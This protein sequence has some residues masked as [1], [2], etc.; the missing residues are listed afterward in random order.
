MIQK[1]LASLCCKENMQQGTILGLREPQLRAEKQVPGGGEC[2]VV[3][4]VSACTTKHYQPLLLL[5]GTLHHQAP[6]SQLLILAHAILKLC[7]S[8]KFHL[9]Q[10]EANSFCIKNSRCLKT[11]YGLF[12]LNP[13][14]TINGYSKL[15]RFYQWIF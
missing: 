10:R 9:Q 4:V 13:I 11:H 14:D 5:L 2:Q 1:I 15:K 3:V 7:P 12:R 8:S 6:A